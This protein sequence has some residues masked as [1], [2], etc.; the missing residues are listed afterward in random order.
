MTCGPKPRQGGQ[1]TDSLRNGGKKMSTLFS[2][3]MALFV[4]ICFVTTSFTGDWFSDDIISF[5]REPT[6]TRD[7]P[8][9][10]SKV[11]VPKATKITGGIVSASSTLVNDW[12][13]PDMLQELQYLFQLGS[14]DPKGAVAAPVIGAQVTGA[15]SLKTNPSREISLE[16]QRGNDWWSEQPTSESAVRQQ[17]SISF[18]APPRK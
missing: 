10:Q 16:D 6:A 18:P 17:I 2:L 14:S 11:T 3:A 5:V 8:N 13:S 12:V 15:Q 7:L 9:P 1:F 4:G